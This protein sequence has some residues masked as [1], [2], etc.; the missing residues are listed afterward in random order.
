R[1]TRRLDDPR[2]ATT[3]LILVPGAVAAGMASMQA[4]FWGWAFGV[5]EPFWT[6]ASALW[7]SRALGSLALAPALLVVI[8]AL[9]LRARLTRCRLGRGR[10][11]PSGSVTGQGLRPARVGDRSDVP[12][13]GLIVAQA[14]VML[15]SPACQAVFHCAPEDLL[16]PYGA[17]IERIDESD[18]ELVQ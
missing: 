12:P 5:H 13:S 16:G 17:W 14:E 4:F 3:F 11:S 2:S 10:A 6:L 18:R 7:I 15:V 8:S 9:L 1:G